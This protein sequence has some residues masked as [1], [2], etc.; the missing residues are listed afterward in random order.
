MDLI[1]ERQK[2]T[3]DEL[4]EVFGV[5]SA[6][7][8]TDLR[9]LQ[10]A[11]LVTRTHGGAIQKTKTGFELNSKQKEVQHLRQKQRI[12]KAALALIDHGDRIIL[13]TGTTTLELAKLL[14]DR[15]NITVITNDLAVA[16]VLEEMEGTDVIVMGGIL[17]KRFHCTIGIQGRDTC[18]GLTVDKAF[19]GANSLCPEKGATTPD[20]GQAETKKMMIEIA[21]HVIV[22]CDSSKINKVS[23]ARFAATDQID[24]IIT[25]EIDAETRTRFEE[26]D[27][28]IVVAER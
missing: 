9:E 11:G 3:V 4:C 13:D 25:D 16:G 1:N 18:S 17:R 20:V 7:V 6:T 5:S 27:V 28:Q 22:L 8:R 26:Q 12:A 21:N 19:M 10:R 2:M 14:D 24:I 15:Q 23:F